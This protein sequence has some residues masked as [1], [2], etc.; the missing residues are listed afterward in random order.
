MLPCIGFLFRLLLFRSV[1]V[2]AW[3]VLC[4]GSCLPYDGVPDDK[5]GTPPHPYPIL[6]CCWN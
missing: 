1:G 2:I 3:E 5:V 4:G 6:S